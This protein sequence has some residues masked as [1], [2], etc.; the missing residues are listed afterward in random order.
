VV[1]RWDLAHQGD[2][3][4][5]RKLS[6]AARETARRASHDDASLLGAGATW[7]ALSAGWW[8][9]DTGREIE[10]PVVTAAA[11]LSPRVNLGAGVPIYHSQD[12]SGVTQSGVGD[13]SLFA[14]VGLIDPAT[15]E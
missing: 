5:D 9:T 10:A 14:K 11:G 12:A 2:R 7:V 15:T 3:E 13:V 1:H 6:R 4:A 8:G